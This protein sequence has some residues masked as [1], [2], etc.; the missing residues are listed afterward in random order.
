LKPDQLF[1][2]QIKAPALA[3]TVAFVH[4]KTGIDHHKSVNVQ[5]GMGQTLL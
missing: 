4:R 2:G 5:E 1:A 3:G